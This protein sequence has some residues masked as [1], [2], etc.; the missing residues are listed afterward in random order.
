MWFEPKYTSLACHRCAS[1]HGS[2]PAGCG[3]LVGLH[4]M[5]AGLDHKNA[6][7]YNIQIKT[8]DCNSLSSTMCRQGLL[9]KYPNIH[10]PTLRR[11]L[12]LK[13]LSGTES[14]DQCW[15]ADTMTITKKYQRRPDSECSMA[16]RGDAKQHCGGAWR[17]AIYANTASTKRSHEASL[18]AEATKDDFLALSVNGTSKALVSG[19]ENHKKRSRASAR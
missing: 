8:Y 13:Q 17:V 15:C 16:C 14:G 19:V 11:T 18:L 6:Q 10:L 1:F 7:W 12:S 4:G 5:L 2:I 9:C 3:R